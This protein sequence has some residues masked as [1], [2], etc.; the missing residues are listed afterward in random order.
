MCYLAS[1][2]FGYLALLGNCP[3]D[4]SVFK[5]SKGVQ[6]RNADARCLITKGM[7]SQAY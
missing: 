5:T 3:L 7:G 1:T 6:V 2:V 4:E